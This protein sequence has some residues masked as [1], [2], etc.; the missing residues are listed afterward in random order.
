MRAPWR[1]R[2][3]GPK[4]GRPLTI[5]FF[6]LFGAGNTGNDGTLEAMLA[7]V[8]RVRTDADLR[9]IC[10]NPEYVEHEFGV[11]SVPIYSE[12]HGGR[13][14]R[15]GAHLLHAWRQLAGCDLLIVPGTGVLDDFGTGPSGLPLAL[16]TWCLAARLRGAGIAFVSIGAGPA[17]H[18][19]S[20][21]LMKRAVGMSFYRSY[22]DHISKDFVKG[23]GIPVSENAVY[24]DLAFSLP[25]P[26]G[27]PYRV[28]PRPSI[29]VGLGI[30]TYQGWRNDAVAG[31][32]LYA[33][34][35]GKITEFALWL[36]DGGRRVRLLMGDGTD[37]RAMTDL[38]EAIRARRPSLQPDQL[39]AE[40]SHTL[41]DLMHQISR[42]DLVVATR[43]HNIVCA[44]KLAR[45]TLS[46]GY[47]KKNDVL[48]EDVGLGRFC[49]SIETLDIGHLLRQ[50]EELEAHAD[51][52]RQTV[53]TAVQRYRTLLEQQEEVLKGHFDACRAPASGRGEHPEDSSSE[54]AGTMTES[55][56][57][58]DKK[59]R[60]VADLASAGR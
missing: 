5:A 44:L 2:R 53:A 23:L 26:S 47:A 24:P 19:L 34:Y 13:I 10:G 25:V 49:Q 48:M 32:G 57:A 1:M 7:F 30:M 36:L 41:H 29:E 20:R 22:R 27:Q 3:Q 43:F 42:T 15:K 18:P 56:G 6:G 50:F 33:D 39:N 54:R 8:R 40:P 4:T 51:R 45:P 14:L 16:F 58:L 17:H 9:C 37:V 28:E 35:I 60:R 59:L 21:L 38:Q 52:W 11:R 46:I 55:P 12:G 31:A